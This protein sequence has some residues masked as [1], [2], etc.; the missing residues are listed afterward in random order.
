M[1]FAF[2]VAVAGGLHLLLGGMLL[3]RVHPR[4]Y[5]ELPFT[6]IYCAQMLLWFASYLVL[7]LNAGLDQIV[8]RSLP[9]GVLVWAGTAIAFALGRTRRSKASAPADAAV[10]FDHSGFLLAA[11][12]AAAILKVALVYSSSSHLGALGL[13]THQHIYWTRQILDAQHLPLVE[14]GTSILALYPRAFHVLTALWSAAGVAGPV[15]P[16]IKLMP[17]LQAFLPCMVFAEL[18]RVQGTRSPALRGRGELLA[19]LLIGALLVY[20]FG[21]TRMV[22]PEY[23]LGGTPRFASGAALMFPYL[24]FT[25]GGVLQS[26]TLRRL[27]WL[28]LPAVALLLLAL[29]AVLVVQLV[30]FMVPLLL[31]ARG[32]SRAND[33]PAR[34]LGPL[35]LAL[36]TLGLPLAIAIGDPWIVALWSAKL[37]D[38]GRWFLDLFGLVTPDQAASLGLLSKDELV[39][40]KPGPVP[41]SNVGGFL[42]LAVASLA[43]GARGWI[44][45][46]WRFPFSDDLFSDPG[47]I[48]VRLGMIATAAFAIFRIRYRS[49]AARPGEHQPAMRLWGGIALAGALG[50]LAQMAT[51]HF[52]AGL[53]VGRGYAFVLLRDYCEIAAR[54]VGLVVQALIL[55]AGIGWAVSVLPRRGGK[56]GSKGREAN[57]AK[58][59]TIAGLSAAVMILPFLLYGLVEPVDPT[60]SF[61]APV[62]SQDIEDLREIESHIADAEA[63]LVP[64]NT[65]GIG[66]ERWI[67]PQGSTASVLPFTTRRILFNSRLGAGV[68]YNWRDL[69]AF[70]LGSNRDRA[71]FLA[72]NDVRWFLLKGPKSASKAFYRNFRMC[73]LPLAA[74]GV[75]HPPAYRAGDLSLYRIDPRTLGV[76]AE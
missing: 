63:V 40:E 10:D 2:S 75:I 44:T 1:P 57:F 4:P 59:W 18:L 36:I 3:R 14:R 31:I 35:L 39:A 46:G 60:K 22:Y 73:K 69:G 58:P 30:I 6:S 53:A 29:N 20:A 11:G 16:W 64:S 61:W 42:R 21:L 74:I 27:S 72:R 45:T 76:R 41:Y 17:F 51:V 62:S 48:I 38:C 52:T 56:E 33:A 24:L 34:P 43:D 12:G 67:I 55:L 5:S 54:H 13:D 37:G 28:V 9:I 66:D 8:G 7:P 32:L 49:E 68:L 15:G 26:A 47:R 50:G 23:D 65:W 71:E 25:A 70:C 19:T